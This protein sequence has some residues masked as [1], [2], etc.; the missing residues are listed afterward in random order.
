VFAVKPSLLREFVA[1]DT[2]DPERPAGV[3]GAWF[4]VENDLVLV[5]STEPGEPT[6]P[7]RTA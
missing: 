7:G 3:D 2:D 4:S 6:D 1:R 5:P